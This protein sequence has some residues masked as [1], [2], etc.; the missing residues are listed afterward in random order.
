MRKIKEILRFRYEVK[1]AYRGIA[2]TLNIGYGTVV[3]YLSR[4]ASAGLG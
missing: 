2:Q 3:D 4:A 1:L